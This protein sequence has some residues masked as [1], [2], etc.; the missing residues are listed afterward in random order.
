MGAKRDNV[1]STIGR[2]PST[3]KSA[4]QAADHQPD[5]FQHGMR[6][7]VQTFNAAH[8]IRVSS[9]RIPSPGLTAYLP[10][11]VRCCNLLS[12]II[13]NYYHAAA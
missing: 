6:D 10:D 7:H 1:N 9:D 4:S 3:G 11:P 8:P 5:A 13:D 2:H 12:G